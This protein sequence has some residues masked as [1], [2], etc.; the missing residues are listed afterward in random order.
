MS[1]Q[2]TDTRTRGLINYLLSKQLS[3]KVMCSELEY[4]SLLSFVLVIE[5]ARRKMQG[6]S[7]TEYLGKVH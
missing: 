3:N 1:V 2:C 6:G 7:R 4:F 5:G